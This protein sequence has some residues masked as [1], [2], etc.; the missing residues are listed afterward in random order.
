MSNSF[1]QGLIGPQIPPGRMDPMHNNA[2]LQFNTNKGKPPMALEGD[3]DQVSST[4]GGDMMGQ[5]FFGSG[6]AGGGGLMGSMMQGPMMGTD[7]SMMMMFNQYGGWG[8][9]GPNNQDMLMQ[10]MP[11]EIIT[12]K[13]CVL[14]PPPPNAPPPTTRERPPGCRTAFVGGLPE[15]VTEEIIGEAFANFGMIVSIRKGKKNFCHIRYELEESVDRSLFLSGYRMKIED[16]DDKPNTG[17]LHVDYAQAR[18]DQYEY[19]CKQRM[20]AREMRHRQRLE[21]DRL[22]PPSPPPIVHYSDHEAYV[23]MEQ[24][25]S[26]DEFMKASQIL[27]TWLERGDLTKRNVTNFYSMIQC[28]NSQV[29]RLLSEKQNQEEALQK[30]KENFRNIFE[31]ILH[32]F[33]QIEKVFSSSRKQRNWDHFSKAQRKNLELWFKQAQEIK[34]NQLEEFLSTRMDDDMEMSDE[35]PSE[36]KKK[37]PDE[38]FNPQQLQEF[39][40]RGTMRE[41]NDSLK[42]QI[43]AYKNELEMMKAE[44]VNGLSE[45]DSQL[46]ILQQAMQGMQQQLIQAKMECKQFENELKAVKQ[47]QL[48]EKKAEKSCEGSEDKEEGTTSEEKQSSSKETSVSTVSST[49]LTLTEK[50][51]KLIGLV[52]C[53]LHV[54][55]NGASVDYIWSYLTQLN[56]ST[57]TSELE[58]LLL[59]LPMLFKLNMSGVGAG[60]EKKW[61]FVAYSNTAFIPFS[62]NS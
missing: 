60:I 19:E 22:H 35:E 26:D 37:K 15:N 32:Q 34:Q 18:D 5:G 16:K 3:P 8:P 59:R 27:M 51:T 54:H 23:L 33:D 24:L 39:L 36:P 20:L 55:P 62:F 29:R 44:K 46:K 2:P 53:F 50:E 7:P 52:S 13:T 40:A 1:N 6:N 47:S 58:E 45:K 10:F 38:P 41:E 11:K 17:R 42:C 61:Q 31:G 28:T 57:R 49:G 30:M 4:G 56:V 21:E 43:E 25:K 48:E 14:Y 12:L 9:M